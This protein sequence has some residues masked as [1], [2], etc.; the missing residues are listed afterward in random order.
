MG[1]K[2]YWMLET[3]IAAGELENLRALMDEMVEAT[4]ENEPGTLMYDW[5]INEAGD[6]CHI[7]EG[8]EDNAAVLV[9]LQAFGKNYASR[10]LKILKPTSFTIYGEPDETV[11]KAL[12]Q[13]GVSY[14]NPFGGFIR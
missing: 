2:V 6:T 8:Y 12:A 7:L 4:R 14:M 9:H 1:S 13:M 5:S 3:S 10:F 11:R